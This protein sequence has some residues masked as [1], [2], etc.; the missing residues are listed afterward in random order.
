MLTLP[1]SLSSADSSIFSGLPAIVLSDVKR[2][3][4]S[5][6]PPL[7]ESRLIAASTSSLTLLGLS[8]VTALSPNATTPILIVRGCF[9][10]KARAATL[11]AS[12]RLGSRSLAR[13]LFET[14]NARITVPSRSGTGRLTVGSRQPEH[15]E[16][17][18]GREERERDVAPPRAPAG[19]RRHEPFGREARRPPAA[20]AEGPHVGEH[21]QRHH[22]EQEQH[23]RRA[24]RHQRRRFRDSTMRTRARHE[25]VLGRDLVDV[26]AGAERQLSQLGL[27][28]LARLAQAMAELG[29]ARVDR[30]L[31]AGLR[32]LDH[33]HAR[34]GKLVLA[35]VDQPDRDDLVTLGQLQQRALPSGR[36]D[37]VGKEND[38]RAPPDCPERELERPRQ[39]GDRP[40][41]GGWLHQ[42]P[43][44]GQHLVAAAPRLD[45]ALDLAVEQDRADGVAAAGEQAGE[46]RRQLGQHELLGA[47]DRAEAH[48][49]RAVEQEPGRQLAILDVLTEER[50]V[51]PRGH[52]PV[53]VAD[54]VTRL[55]LAQIVEVRAD[56]AEDRP[57]VPLQ[58]AVQA[59]DHLPLEAVEDS[60]GCLDAGAQGAGG[61]RVSLGVAAP[62][63]AMRSRS[64]SSGTG[65]AAR[66]RSMIASGVTPS[67]SAS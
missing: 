46:R 17:D 61:S 67:A 32:V 13:M 64:A 15:D 51:H 47:V 53:D 12:I 18:P 40:A 63:A 8:T 41:C 19:G 58:P 62:Y 6:V 34:V 22:R 45:R 25:V 31:L 43:G 23:P 48:R 37:E 29:V 28:R 3:W 21:E 52:V 26:D 2:P 65:T 27:P 30:E 39:V 10:T 24:E 4:P 59:A 5:D 50:R 1:A 38:E 54:V 20:P 42:A 9:S 11:A 7:T 33:D 49:R 44:Q 14:S 35:R 60:L 55:V 36:G 57:V 16:G 66:M 56:P